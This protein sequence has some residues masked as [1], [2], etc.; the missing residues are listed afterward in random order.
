MA[1]QGDFI[2]GN[3][4]YLYVL[5]YNCITYTHGCMKTGHIVKNLSEINI[6]L[7]NQNAT[8]VLPII[9]VQ[10]IKNPVTSIFFCFSVIL[11]VPH[12]APNLTLCL[13]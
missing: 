13:T 6:K 3:L 7:I 4:M 2:V 8:H 5:A 10:I 12:N 1:E 9:E 11:R